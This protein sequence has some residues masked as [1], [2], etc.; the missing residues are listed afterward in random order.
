M[1]EFM[2][3]AMD[4]VLEKEADMAK[5]C[6]AKPEDIEEQIEKIKEKQEKLTKQY[7][8]DMAEF[9]HIL[10]KLNAIKNETLKCQ[11]K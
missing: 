6:Y 2:K 3:K 4:W 11:S 7:N 5:N 1:I 9:E 8:E 10:E